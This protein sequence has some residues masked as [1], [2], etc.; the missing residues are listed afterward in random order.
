MRKC[1]RCDEVMVEDYMLKTEN[2]TAV[3]SVVLAK[4]GGIFSSNTKGKVKAAVCPKCGEISI[5]FDEL[6]KIK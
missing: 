5:F 2:L 1:L 6:N 3:A 4:G